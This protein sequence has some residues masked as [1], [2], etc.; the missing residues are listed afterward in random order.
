MNKSK[1]GEF[2]LLTI[3]NR[4]LELDDHLDVTASKGLKDPQSETE[5]QDVTN[6]FKNIQQSVWKQIIEL[7]AKPKVV[8]MLNDINKGKYP[9]NTTIDMISQMTFEFQNKNNTEIEDVSSILLRKL[10]E[11]VSERLCKIINFYNEQDS[12]LKMKKDNFDIFLPL[13]T[14]PKTTSKSVS[15]NTG[16]TPNGNAQNQSLKQDEYN[17]YCIADIE[18]VIDRMIIDK[19]NQLISET[20]SYFDVSYNPFYSKTGAELEHLKEE[21]KKWKPRRIQLCVAESFIQS[22]IFALKL[23]LLNKNVL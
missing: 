18:D 13:P 9:S 6:V 12:S 16:S 3:R 7:T 11:S 14:Q 1:A 10:S 21:S 8:D 17:Y 2:K 22:T 19:Q 5:L 20:P 4:L 15:N 23:D